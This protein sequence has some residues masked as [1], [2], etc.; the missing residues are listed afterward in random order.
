M[1]HELY[2]MEDGTY[3]MCRAVNTASSWHGLENVVPT[4]APFE[5]WLDRS[6]MG[7]EIKG[8][9]VLY[10]VDGDQA[11]MDD[12]KVL[13]RTDTNKALSV[14]STDYH[15]VQPYQ[16]LNFFRD[17][18]DKYGLEMDTA[19][20]IRGGV[21]FWALAR[22]GTELNVGKGKDIIKQY[23]LLASSADASMATTAKHTTMRVVCSNT[24][25]ASINN[26]ESAIKVSH[27]KAFNAND[28]KMDLGLLNDEFEQFGYFAGTMHDSKVTDPMAR[29]WFAE[30]LS[31]KN[32]LDTDQ[33]NTY[34][35]TSRLFQTIFDSY[36]QGKGAENTVWGLF[37]A[38][39]YTVDHVRGRT[40]D[41]QL[42]S[43]M[44][45]TGAQLKQKAWNKALAL[46]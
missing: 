19:G 35:S 2:L 1:A 31:G 46:V 25:H 9:K 18:C 3:S 32:D 44:F 29:K 13:F 34:A 26:G 24:F 41:S 45:G 10:D 39:T 23:I 15:I 40:V 17:L 5:T 11:S 30:M 38:V 22:T 4:D 43:S 14:V 37:N 42:D 12:R 6:G 36:K 33:I 7:F 20:C 16:V 8:S 27:S 21:K 28:V